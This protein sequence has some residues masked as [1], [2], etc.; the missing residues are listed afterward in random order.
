MRTIH[1]SSPIG[2]NI[3]RQSPVRRRKHPFHFP[4]NGLAPLT[5]GHFSSRSVN[6]RTR[7]W[8]S[9]GRAVKSCRASGVI[10]RTTLATL[11]QDVNLVNFYLKIQIVSSA[12]PTP[13]AP[14]EEPRNASGLRAVSFSYSDMISAS[15]SSA[16]A[17][18]FARIATVPPL[19][20]PV[21]FAP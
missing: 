11:C 13:H 2:R 16:F 3:N 14:G 18:I 20:P 19:P 12:V 10:T 9:T 1:I 8:I 7:S 4:R 15:D 5:F 17:E 21:I 6:P